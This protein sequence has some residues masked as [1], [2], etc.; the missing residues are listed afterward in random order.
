M[1]LGLPVLVGSA[2][3]SVLD[4]SAGCSGISCISMSLSDTA[5]FP[6]PPE[7]AWLCLAR[8]RF[9]LSRQLR[10]FV[11]CRP[12]PFVVGKCLLQ[13]RQQILL[14]ILTRVIRLVSD[15]AIRK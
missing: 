8:T 10:F 7:D 11:I 5:P 2:G 6:T 9:L 14:A 13:Y 4:D 1:G 15:F 3:W 12:S